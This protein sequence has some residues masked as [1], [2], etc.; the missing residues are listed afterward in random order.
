MFSWDPTKLNGLYDSSL[1]SLVYS[2]EE[3]ASIEDPLLTLG[4]ESDEDQGDLNKTGAG[5]DESMGEE[6]ESEE[7]NFDDTE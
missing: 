5:T 1:F 6:E 3:E 7:E 2:D 4:S